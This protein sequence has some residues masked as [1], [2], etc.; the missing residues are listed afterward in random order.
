MW[1]CDQP[2][3]IPAVGSQE[4]THVFKKNSINFLKKLCNVFTWSQSLCL[5]FPLGEL[6]HLL[7][8]S[9]TAK[10]LFHLNSVGLP[11]D[12]CCQKILLPFFRLRLCLF[13]GQ[14]ST[15]L[16]CLLAGLMLS[17]RVDDLLGPL[18]LHQR[19]G[20]VIPP[21]SVH[22]GENLVLEEQLGSPVSAHIR[23]N[24][25]QKIPDFQGI[26]LCDLSRW[27]S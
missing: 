18:L 2:G 27:E 3:S 25:S 1:L 17:D 4:L 12:F 16:H 6:V 13:E 10:S 14:P 19:Q 5:F 15:E 11:T 20:R 9:E 26:F 8:L 23:M 24:C 21:S 7:Q 22:H